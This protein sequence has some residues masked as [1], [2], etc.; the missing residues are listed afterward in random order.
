MPKFT[1]TV[2]DNGIRKRVVLESATEPTEAEVLS[3]LRE[4]Y[5]FLS[6]SDLLAL[7]KGDYS[8]ISTEG[9]LALKSKQTSSQSTNQAPSQKTPGTIEAEVDGIGVLEFPAGTSYEVIQSAVKRVIAERSVTGAQQKNTTPKPPPGWSIAEKSIWWDTT[10]P[11]F[12]EVSGESATGLILFSPSGRRFQW[13]NSTSLSQ[14]DIDQLSRLKTES[15]GIIKNPPE[16]STL[17]NRTSTGL[18]LTGWAVSLFAAF[19]VSWILARRRYNRQS[20]V[21]GQTI[22]ETESIPAS[23]RRAS[24]GVRRLASALF[25][26]FTIGCSSIAVMAADYDL[27]AAFVGP[28]VGMT[29]WG[30]IRGID[31]IVRGFKFGGYDIDVKR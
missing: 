7:K 20:G 4:D 19:A 16:V 6:D 21:D 28:F 3:A 15:V 11:G 26:L 2:N 9:L 24:L 10:P 17:L 31:W 1:V 23:F 25:W 29:F 18:F 13:T 27:R 14:S 22:Q 30:L 12:K 5:S 8:S